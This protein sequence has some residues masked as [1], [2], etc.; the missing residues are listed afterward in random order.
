MTVLECCRGAK[1]IERR[2]GFEGLVVNGRVEFFEEWM[3][4]EVFVRRWGVGTGVGIFAYELLRGM[5]MR[6][7]PKANIRV[8]TSRMRG[9]VRG[10]CISQI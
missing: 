2:C 1:D 8:V 6:E 5:R 4:R 10:E 3:F 7:S 9:K